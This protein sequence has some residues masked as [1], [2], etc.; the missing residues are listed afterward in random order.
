M[1]HGHRADRRDL[2]GQC[3]DRVAGRRSRGLGRAPNLS[4][5]QDRRSSVPSAAPLST[6]MTSAAPSDA[7]P[8]R[9]SAGCC[10]PRSGRHPHRTPRAAAWRNRQDPCRSFG[11]GPLQAEGAIGFCWSKRSKA[12]SIPICSRWT[13]VRTAGSG[14]RARTSALVGKRVLDLAMVQV[15]GNCQLGPARCQRPGRRT[16]ARDSPAR[17][18]SGQQTT[19]GPRPRALWT[20][21]KGHSTE[22]VAAA[23]ARSLRFLATI[24]ISAKDL[25]VI[26]RHRRS[27]RHGGC[28]MSEIAYTSAR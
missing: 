11:T 5:P 17:C 28:S 6:S 27:G 26:A 18:Q 2:T 13:S 7:T 24:G 19:K 8:P 4:R 12:D 21:K 14:V 10:V 15:L 22:A 23:N 1:R 3:L 25:R 9:S 16:A 20:S